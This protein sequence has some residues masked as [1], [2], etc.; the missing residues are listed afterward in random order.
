MSIVWFLL[1]LAIMSKELRLFIIAG[2]SSGDLIGSHIMESVNQITGNDVSL[3]WSGIGGEYMERQGLTSL[4]P[5]KELS[6]MGFLEVLPH[7]PRILKRIKQTVSAIRELQPDIVITIDS[8][9]FCFRIVKALANF[10]GKKV[11]VV[12]PTVWAYRP[13]RAE[14]IAKLY[15]HLFVLLPF[16]PP[17]FEKEGLS[18]TFIGHPIAHE[19]SQPPTEEERRTFFANAGFDPN[20]TTLGVL[21]GSRQSE[22][23][24]LWP[25]YQETLEEVHKTHPLQLIIPTTEALYP[26]MQSLIKTLPI[27]ALLVK[28]EQKKQLMR[29]MDAALTKSGTNILEL[30]KSGV[31]MIVTYK[32]NPITGWLAKRIVRVPYVALVNLV[33]SREAIPEFL[34]ENCREEK[35]V[36]ALHALLEDKDAQALQRKDFADALGQLTNDAHVT[37]GMMVA[38]MLFKIINP[39]FKN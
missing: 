21:A 38:T 8:P 26:E 20:V 32:T 33:L 12:A 31:P 24:R 6:I 39:S 25:V 35:L 14:K 36:P 28:D 23:D 1:G 34:L 17:Y 29:M 4:F 30:A 16:E 37:P 9:D 10:S 13:K 18:T 3:A 15:D 22:V 7:I 27:K 5:M 11:H 2:E 19:D